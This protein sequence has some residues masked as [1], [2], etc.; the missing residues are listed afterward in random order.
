[1]TLDPSN[2]LSTQFLAEV[3]ASLDRFCDEQR[4]KW[5]SLTA[6]RMSLLWDQLDHFLQAGKRIR[7]AFCYW[8]YVAVEGSHP[9]SPGII[10]VAASLDLL[11]G[12]AL[13]HD[14]LIDAS[15]TRRGSPSAHRFFEGYH[16][17]QSWLGDSEHFGT[18]SAILLGD[19][20]FA[21]SVSMVEKADVP[22][23]R[24]ARARSYLDE[25]RTEVLAG[26]FLDL[27]I[28][29]RPLNPSTLIDDACFVM[30]FKTAKYTVTRPMMV[31]AGLALASEHILQGFEIFGAHVGR[32]FQMRDD[33]LGLFGD[34]EVTGKP[35]GDDLRSGKKTVVIGYALQDASHRDAE[36]LTHMLGNPDLTQDDIDQARQILVD[37]GAV[38][39][40]QRAITQ[41]AEAGIKI[42][43]SCHLSSEGHLGLVGLVQACVER[44]A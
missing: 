31:G 6:D 8:A 23:E 14:D 27:L 39:R 11:Q 21:W 3:Q 12:F 42:L 2:P 24:L 4:S 18:S 33:L 30:E 20:L 43:D 15:D 22:P 36:R 28:E 37:C 32:A 13:I 34:S 26:Q 29:T 40:T 1:M 16:A 19:L 41:A 35:S 7:P 25:V 38:D 9:T 10:D 5:T 17:S 44:S